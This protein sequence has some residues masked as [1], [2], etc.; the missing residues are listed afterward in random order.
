MPTPTPFTRADGS[1]G[2]RVRFRL[3]PGTNPVSETFDDE[4]E[5]V[6][7]CQL[8]DQVGGQAARNIRDATSDSEP[9][10]TVRTAFEEYCE[11]SQVQP[12][13]IHKNRRQWDLYASEFFDHFPVSAVT[14]E[15]AQKWV[16]ALAKRETIRSR[17]ARRRSPDLAPVCLSTKTIANIQGLVSSVFQAEVEAGRISINPVRKLALPRTGKRRKPVFL[18]GAQFE[19]LL[20]CVPEHWQPFVLFL[21]S[22]GLRFSEATALTVHDFDL[23][24]AQPI[25]RVDKAWKRGGQGQAAYV[26]A[27]K[28]DFG[29]RTV[30]L[31]GALIPMLRALVECADELVF[32]TE[33]GSRVTDS[34]FHGKVWQ[35]AVSR[36]DLGVR[37]TVHDLRHSHASWLINRGVPLTVIQRRLGHSSIK[38]TSDIYGHIQPDAW[39]ATAQAAGEALEGITVP[40]LES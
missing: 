15:H 14:R 38:V 21:G 25:V 5:A 37:P 12:D 13:T 1:V 26:G 4:T 8:V 28:T 23:D 10:R 34:T 3:S 17:N 31:P 36:A 7:F 30:S 16:S 6:R 40:V 27:P 9:S 22:T 32:T 19:A 35:D 29:Y 24:A 18:T 33:A 20:A 39:L 2:Y 11:R